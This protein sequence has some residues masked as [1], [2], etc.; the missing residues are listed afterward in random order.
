MAQ[1]SSDSEQGVIAVCV[2]NQSAKTEITLTDADGNVI[3]SYPPALSFAV[4]ILS[5]PDMIKGEEYTITVGGN[6]STFEAQ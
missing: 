1:T 3:I 2:G 5:S 4:V 6:S